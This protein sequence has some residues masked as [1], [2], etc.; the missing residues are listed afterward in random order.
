MV[1]WQSFQILDRISRRVLQRHGCFSVDREGQDVHALRTSIDIVRQGQNPLV[2]FAE[3]EV[4]HNGERVYPFHSGPAAIALSAARRTERRV[5]LLPAAIRHHYLVDPTPQLTP[6]VAE[7]ERRLGIPARAELPLDER[8][9]EVAQAVLALREKQQLGD[10]RSGPFRERVLS[11]LDHV[12]T[13]LG[14][15]YGAAPRKEETPGRVTHLRR[16]AIAAKEAAAPGSPQQLTAQHD[17]DDLLLATQLYS[18]ADDYLTWPP[19]V[20]H[21]SEI[22]D[23]FEEDV[24]NV[25]TARPRGPRQATILLGEPIEAPASR[26]DRHAAEK[27]TA[28]LEDQVR[29]LLEELRREQPIALSSRAG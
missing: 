4:Y 6:L 12:L 15:K 11:L 3:G 25:I 17:L 28:A 22:V 16:Q 2:I 29:G 10:V 1:A 21:L 26:G 9:R 27:L 7:M 18:Y 5:V 8:V 23:K 13:R 24:L 20:E 14:A 19:S